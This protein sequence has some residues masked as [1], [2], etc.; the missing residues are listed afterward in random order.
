ML[1]L[2]TSFAAANKVLMFKKY[3]LTIIA[4]VL[5]VKYGFEYISSDDFQKYGDE[6]KAGWTCYVNN[7]LGNLDIVMS[8]YRDAYKLFERVTVRCPETDM[9]AEASFKMAECLAG[10]GYNAQAAVA[11]EQYAEKHPTTRRARLAIRSASILKGN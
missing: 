4:V 9:E 7:I 3:F 11:Y 1:K 2:E 8:E 10:S 5:A 6:K